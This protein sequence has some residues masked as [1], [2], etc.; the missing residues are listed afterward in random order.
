MKSETIGQGGIACNLIG[1]VKSLAVY[2]SLLQPIMPATLA[3]VWMNGFLRSST[4]TRML[5]GTVQKQWMVIL[6]AFKAIQWEFLRLYEC[7]FVCGAIIVM[8]GLIWTIQ[9]LVRANLWSRFARCSLFAWNGDLGKRAAMSLNGCFQWNSFSNNSQ[10]LDS[11]KDS[12][13]DGM[14]NCGMAK[15]AAHKDGMYFHDDGIPVD[16]RLHKLIVL[17]NMQFRRGWAYECIQALC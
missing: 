9:Q 2:L 12:I 5:Q 14:R 6:F 3:D 7:F 10:P 8:M 17:M 13:V 15:S 4:T 11:Q 1:V 16:L